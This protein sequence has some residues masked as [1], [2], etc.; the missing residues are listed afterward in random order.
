MT[1][2][3]CVYMLQCVD[4]SYYVGQTDQLEIRMAQHHE[5]AFPNCYTFERRPVELVWFEEFVSRDES[6]NREHQLKGWSRKKK[7]ALIEKDWPRVSAHSR[8]RER[9]GRA[10][11]PA[12]RASAQRDRGEE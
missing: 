3:F 9:P 5:G 8:G 12:L 1:P 2:T 11:T 6:L 7:L 4:G 10:S